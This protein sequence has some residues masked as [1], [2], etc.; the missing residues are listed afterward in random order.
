MQ[1]RSRRSPK[2]PHELLA[3]DLRQRLPVA[4]EGPERDLPKVDD[5]VG[6]L[7][8]GQPAL[9]DLSVA[10][11]GGVSTVARTRSMALLSCSVAV[12][13][14]ALGGGKDEQGPERQP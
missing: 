3:L 13:P 7:T 6:D 4:P 8:N 2:E 5:V 14:R 1:E 10:L 12:A 9:G 11:E